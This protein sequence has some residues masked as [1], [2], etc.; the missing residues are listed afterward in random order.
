MSCNS[1]YEN[2]VGILATNGYISHDEMHAA[3]SHIQY[4]TLKHSSCNTVSLK[5]PCAKSRCFHTS[6][7]QIEMHYN[8]QSVREIKD[9]E[10]KLG[11][12]A[13]SARVTT[14]GVNFS[15]NRISVCF[16]TVGRMSRAMR[17]KGDLSAV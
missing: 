9:E 5:C 13:F 6:L 17:R 16:V 12:A 10:M 7:W 8:K 3:S 2:C 15:Y 1:C 14:Q 4:M 11:R